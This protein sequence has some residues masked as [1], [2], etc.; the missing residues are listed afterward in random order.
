MWVCFAQKA[1]LKYIFFIAKRAKRLEGG[2]KKKLY[3]IKRET[4]KTSATTK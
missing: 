2:K 3:Q 4:P 1:K